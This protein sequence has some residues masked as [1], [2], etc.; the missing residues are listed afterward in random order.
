M[1]R[2]RDGKFKYELLKSLQ[3]DEYILIHIDIDN[4]GTPMHMAPF[5]SFLT[6]YA[7]KACSR[8]LRQTV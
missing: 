7:G 8:R 1:D 4:K 2:R 6:L 3:L 5:D